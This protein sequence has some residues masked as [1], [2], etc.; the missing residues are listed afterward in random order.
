[1]RLIDNITG[2]DYDMLANDHY[3][4]QAYN[5]D[6]AARFYIVFDVTGVDEV[7]DGSEIFA[8]FNGTGWAVE[9]Q[10][11]I[12][13]VDMLGQVLYSDYLSG[14]STVVNFGK[15]AAGTYLLRLGEKTQKIIIY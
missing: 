10:G 2:T 11:V 9:G 5:T 13:L 12:Q 14:D 7:D 3:T 15:V 8:Y 1:M 6:Y 4:F